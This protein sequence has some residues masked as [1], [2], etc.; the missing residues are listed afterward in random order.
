MSQT[1]RLAWRSINKRP[2]FSLGVVA[3][4]AL[5]VAA[6]TSVF[7]VVDGVLL[8][9]LPYPEA[10]R[11]V[12]FDNSSHPMP[13]FREWRET[14]E[15]E[16]IGAVWMENFALS[17]GERPLQVRG[18]Q[19]TPG[20]LEVFAARPASGRLLVESDW[21]E[22]ARPVVLSS[23]LARQLD[24]EAQVLGE[25]LTLNGTPYEVVGVMAADFRPPEALTGREVDLWVPLPIDHR[26]AESRNVYVLE[27]AARLRDGAAIETA[28][29][30]LDALAEH[31][32]KAYP[33]SDAS[34]DG[35]P[36]I[37]PLVPLQQATTQRAAGSLGLLLGAVG[38]LML[39]AIANVACLFLA[40]ATQREREVAVLA[41]LGASRRRVMTQ[42]LAESS[43][44][45]VAGGLLGFGL[46]HL[47]VSA[48]RAY[49]PIPMPRLDAVVVDL[50]VFA[51]AFLLSLIAG[52]ACGVVPALGAA[53]TDP[54]RAFR[55]TGTGSAVPKQRLRSALVVAEVAMAV[56]LLT[57]AGL[58]FRS[59]MALTSVDPGFDTDNLLRIGLERGRVDNE[60]Q[61]EEQV[62]FVEQ[63]VD[64]VAALPGVEGAA[65]GWTMPFDF[66]GGGRCCWFTRMG[67]TP[68]DTDH[69][70]R[71]IV[72]PMTP[73]VFE[74]L[75]MPLL[76]G[77]LFDARD[78]DREPAVTVINQAL[79]EQLFPD[80]PGRSAVGETLYSTG[81]A[82]MQIVGVVGSV[83]HYGLDSEASPA[84]YVPFSALGGGVPLISLL[85]STP[86]P[87][88]QLG[89][90]LRQ[91]IWRLDPELPVLEIETMRQRVAQSVRE[92]KFFSLLFAGFAAVALLLA[93]GGVYA[94]LLFVVGTRRREVGIRMALGAL[95][96]QI[97]W[98]MIGR[99]MF[100]VGAGA[101]IGVLA[102]LGLTRYLESLLYQVTPREPI[103]LAAG[104]VILSLVGLL[105]SYLPAR[106]S[107]S[108]EPMKTL[109]AE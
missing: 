54:A 53:R 55:D 32:A 9:A 17:G 58:L 69:K 34:P 98:M 2:G 103:S 77:R 52:V 15:F 48:F 10:D 88:E 84:I 35:E 50:R 106:R 66:T 80:D 91:A 71:T 7:S 109:R 33:D 43:L 59:V 85:V 78:R 22:G 47:A 36:A 23:G 96:R 83:H 100:L 30:R 57:G 16:Q 46:A 87:A 102:S 61:D 108:L 97:L 73:G 92:P 12:Y 107:A 45:S 40:R 37:T 105:A 75:G 104:V 31:N 11:I 90:S 3:L 1:L 62:R 51:F 86:L 42:M 76:E 72:H 64:E 101:V 8:R 39:I 95:R 28:Q 19:L 44:L 38:L 70:V 82:Q 89:D 63:L 14:G 68:T 67:V 56:V 26:F 74:L 49:A 25:V 20:F 29:A 18:A 24:A 79:A 21:R 81:D 60:S 41:A 93:A 4:V 6:V 99:G 5:G 94:A 65:A 27:V 13:R